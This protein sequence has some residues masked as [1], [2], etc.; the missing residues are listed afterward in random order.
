[1]LTEADL[2][3]SDGRTLHYYDVAEGGSGNRLAVFWHHGTPNIGAPP[4]PLYDAGLRWV[5]HDR[6]GYGG[7]SAHPGRDVGSVAADV[8][9]IA[10]ALG[11]DQFAVVGHSGGGPHALACGALLPER[12]LA[13][14]SIS[15]P[16]PYDAQGLDWFAG[17]QPGQVAEQ[18]A[19]EAGRAALEEYQAGPQ[20]EEEVFT[21]ED[22]AALSGNWSWVLEVVH[23]AIAGDPAGQLDDL[24]ASARPWGFS[25]ADIGAPVLVV[26][27]GR[28]LMVPSSHGEWI[29]AHCPTAELRIAPEDGHVSVLD[30]AP[31]ALQ[32]LRHDKAV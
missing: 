29:A 18:R 6:P 4:V 26:H 3:L 9:S 7:S 10:D 21:D 22:K 2:H 13:V 14:V 16:A 24:V 11:I 17:M 15:A 28:D 19:A 32:W 20:P 12:V 30:H 8:S 1:M 25:P 23:A 31:A 5:S 27:G